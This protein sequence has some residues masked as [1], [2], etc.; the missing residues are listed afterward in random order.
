M[1]DRTAVRVGFDL[2][3]EVKVRKGDDEVGNCTFS[4]EAVG[5]PS[6]LGVPLGCCAFAVDDEVSGTVES[7]ETGV[8][9]VEFGF[10]ATNSRD[11]ESTLFDGLSSRVESGAALSS[12]GVLDLS[13]GSALWPL[14]SDLEL[15]KMFL[16]NSFFLPSVRIDF[17]E[18]PKTGSLLSVS[19]SFSVG[20][21]L[22]SSFTAS[23]NEA[24]RR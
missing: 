2:V 22:S 7:T 3:G 18:D 13:G 12:T 19:R 4:S 14:E 20:S 11:D 1:D 8:C 16:G 5:C 24:T 21:P 10:F 17:G 9:A 15:P 6:L 23:R